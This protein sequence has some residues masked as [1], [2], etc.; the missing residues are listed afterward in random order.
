MV[1][2]Q[3][4][5]TYMIEDGTGSIDIKQWNMLEAEGLAQ[6]AELNSPEMQT[7]DVYVKVFG[8]LQS[9]SDRMY[10]VSHSI[11]RIENGNEVSFHFL[12][13]LHAHLEMTIEKKPSFSPFF[14]HQ[15][16]RNNINSIVKRAIKVCGDE[17]AGSHISNIISH[18]KNMFTEAEVL[19]SLDELADDGQIYSLSDEYIH[20]VNF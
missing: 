16:G 13:A 1:Q 10:C 14:S 18:L 17:E 5:N 11:I 2:Q 19:K 8:R 12:N 7:C 20:L 3:S 9:F 15:I 6:Q 4:Y